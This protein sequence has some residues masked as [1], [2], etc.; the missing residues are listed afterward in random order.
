MV[1][2]L[3]SHR[4]APGF[5]RLLV[6]DQHVGGIQPAPARPSIRAETSSGCPGGMRAKRAGSAWAKP[7]NAAAT[8]A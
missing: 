2:P 4:R 6:P 7:A 8:R 3:A 5:P 1:H